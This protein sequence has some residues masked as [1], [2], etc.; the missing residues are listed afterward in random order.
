MNITHKSTYS[1]DM[2]EAEFKGLASFILKH[3]DCA[4]DWEEVYNMIRKHAQD[5]LDEDDCAAKRPSPEFV[6]K[7]K[8][9][10]QKMD[11]GSWDR[12]NVGDEVQS[13]RFPGLRFKVTRVRESG[14]AN[15]EKEAYIPHGHYSIIKRTPEHAEVGDLISI[16][17]DV[18]KPPECVGK[19]FEVMAHHD[20]KVWFMVD[21]DLKWLTDGNYTVVK[22]ALEELDG[23]QSAPKLFMDDSIIS[24]DGLKIG[25]WVW[26]EAE[27]RL[28]VVLSIR[29]QRNSAWATVALLPESNEEYPM[30]HEVEYRNGKWSDLF[31]SKWTDGYSNDFQIVDPEVTNLS[32]S[33]LVD[34]LV[35]R[36][37]VQQLTVCPHEHYLVVTTANEIRDSGPA[38]I[39]VVTD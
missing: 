12:A 4:S 22:R 1:L 15:E 10:K 19:E 7:A 9:I 30:F 36:T 23:E 6:K 3:F 27:N 2:T 5:L 24:P 31:K 11:D 26:D 35:K 28:G 25:M 33:E 13:I 32:T 29:K 8:E 17:T 38:R 39:L 16:H 18:P 20:G 37:G 34:M 14:V 21:N